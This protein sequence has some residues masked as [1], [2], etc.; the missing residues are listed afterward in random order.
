MK[1]L[2]VKQG[3]PEWVALRKNFIGASDAPIIMEVSPW[4]TPNQLWREKMGLI[5]K[6]ETAA[7][8]R[9]NELEPIA[10]QKFIEEI[11][12]EVF[13]VVAVHSTVS[14]L[15]A[16]FDGLSESGELAVE[17]K[18]PGKEDHEKAMNG[19][20][21]EKYIPQLQH[22]MEVA[23]LDSMFYFS[24][25][26]R[27]YKILEI[28][29]DTDYFQKL[30]QKEKAFWECMQNLEE[31]ELIDRDYVKRGDEE[32][33]NLAQELKTILKIEDR[34][35]EIRKRLIALSGG[36]NSMGGGIKLSKVRRKGTVDYKSIPELSGVNLEKYRKSS[37]ET[38]RIGV[39]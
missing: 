37:I 36:L 28:E 30:Y 8:R 39:C 20:I 10:R 6:E 32:W 21:P 11:G 3:S 19:I 9:G 12:Y 38:Y 2:N 26:D 24:Y 16:S 23:G 4:T 35:E 33:E 27:S 22:Q 7:M 17:I 15:L 13:P 18:C 5:T 1:K 34:K 31:P 29:K 14:F 25:N